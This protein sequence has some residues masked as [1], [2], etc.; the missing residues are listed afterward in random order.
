MDTAASINGRDSDETLIHT[1]GCVVSSRVC[2]GTFCSPVLG[3]LE[4]LEIR[5]LEGAARNASAAVSIAPHTTMAGRAAVY[6]LFGPEWLRVYSREYGCSLYTYHMYCILR[7]LS[8]LRCITRRRKSVSASLHYRK[9]KK[10]SSSDCALTGIDTSRS[11]FQI[12]SWVI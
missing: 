10:S 7:I 8:V 3:I 11:I 6:N 4:A 2:R 5:A 1:L 12:D 9:N